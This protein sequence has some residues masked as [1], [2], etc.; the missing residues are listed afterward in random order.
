M[1]DCKP[2]DTLITKGEGL[3]RR[4]CPKTPQEKEQMARV[5]Y[6]NVVGSLVYTMMCTR[7]D[8]CYAVGMVSRYQ[9]NL[10]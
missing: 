4:M 9:S 6:S 3:T 1:Q 7:P 10:G 5:P 8:I 2:V